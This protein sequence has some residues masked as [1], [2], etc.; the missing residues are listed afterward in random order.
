MNGAPSRNSGPRD[1][2]MAVFVG[3]ALRELRHAAAL[4]HSR[5]TPV[6]IRRPLLAA[7]DAVT[8]ALWAVDY[9]ASVTEG[10][11]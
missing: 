2:A 8:S 1:R 7:H 11:E 3:T 6:R 5:K 4:I 10:D 9:A